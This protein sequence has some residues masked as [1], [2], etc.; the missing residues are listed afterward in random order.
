MKQTKKHKMTPQIRR[1][2]ENLTVSLPAIP[3]FIEGKNGMKVQ[4]IATSRLISGKELKDSGGKVNDGSD[5]DV[6]KNYI[7]KGTNVRMMNHKVM[8]VQQYE[9]LGEK[10][11]N[12]YVEYVTLMDNMIKNPPKPKVSNIEKGIG[13]KPKPEDFGWNEESK[14]WTVDGGEQAYNKACA[15]HEESISVK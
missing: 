15:E 2:I 11:I 1:E 12:D 10:G 3:Y 7:Q 5:I 6:N 8:L 14:I 13:E 4:R 9:K